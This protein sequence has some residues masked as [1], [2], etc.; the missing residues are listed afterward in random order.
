MEEN[1][2]NNKMMR[3]VVLPIIVAIIS[4]VIIFVTNNAI[5]YDSGETIDIN[6][7]TATVKEI[8]D[9]SINQVSEDISITEVSFTAELTSGEKAGTLIQMMQSIDEL[10]LPVPKQVEAG[11]NILV[12]DSQLVVGTEN[13]SDWYY[14]GANKT[15]NLLIIVGVFVLLILIIGRLKGIAAVTSLGISI[16]SIFLM[17]I[18]AILSGMNIYIVTILIAMFIILSNLLILNGFN[19]K[20][21]CAILGNASGVLVAGL[22]AFFVNNWVG[23]TGVVDQEYIFLTMLQNDVSIDLIALVWGA[24]IIGSLG[25]VMDVAVSISSS[26]HELSEQMRNKT[27]GA[28][29]RSGMNIGRD[30]I[31]T[32]TNTLILAYVGSSLALMLLFAANN[33]DLIILLNFEM[34]IVEII[35][36]VVGSIGILIAVPLTVLASAWIYNKDTAKKPM[37]EKTLENDEVIVEE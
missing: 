28:M 34:I 26:L 18:P 13:A 21:L 6:V 9:I 7:E 37:L 10:Y 11:D 35:Q 1:F 5:N 32:M 4:V 16:A 24:I 15:S 3:N 22:V 8:L 33:R 29:V 36:A 19:K 23:V 14:T 20:T 25:A 12:S 31:G 27:F 2:L 17:Y 30:V